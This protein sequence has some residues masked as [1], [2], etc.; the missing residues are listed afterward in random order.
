MNASTRFLILSA[1]L[2]TSG[3]VMTREMP[4][5]WQQ[6]LQQPVT[7]LNA[8]SGTYVNGTGTERSLMRYFWEK[9]LTPAPEKI[10]LRLLDQNRLEITALAKGAAPVVKIVDV[11][12]NRSTGGVRPPTVSHVDAEKEG[13]A[14]H[15][16]GI[17]LLKGSDGRLYGHT[18]SGGAAAF[19][20]V[21]PI[22]AD[23][24]SW[25]RW[26]PAESP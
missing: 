17:Q 15:M 4:A 12:V 14:L 22:V 3:C 24:K 26:A 11:D 23:I 18:A 20:W 10:Q 21:I 16:M 13:V 1:W 19:A 8:I 6:P 7:A 5:D 9:P 25:R 2:L